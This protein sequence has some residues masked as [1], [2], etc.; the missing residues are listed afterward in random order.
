MFSG[1]KSAI[2]EEAE[3][4]KLVASDVTAD[5]DRRLELKKRTLRE[6]DLWQA[7]VHIA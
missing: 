2:L 5:F 1:G 4:V 3:E 6:E 7:R